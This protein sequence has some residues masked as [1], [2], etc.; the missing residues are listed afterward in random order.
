M[1]LV[2][3]QLHLFHQSNVERVMRRAGGALF[4]GT[5]VT[6]VI[7][8]PVIASEATEHG[9]ST[10]TIDGVSVT[11]TDS[12]KA[13]Y[14]DLMEDIAEDYSVSPRSHAFVVHTESLTWI[15]FTDQEPEVAEVQI[16]GE[17]IGTADGVGYIFANSV[18]FDAVPEPAS[19][20]TLATEP[21][22]H[23]YELVT[24]TTTYRQLSYAF[25]AAGG[26][27]RNQQ[28][29]GMAT[30]GSFNETTFPME[31]GRWANYGV[32][33]LSVAKNT[34]Q[35][36]FLAAVPLLSSGESIHAFGN[37]PSFG[38]NGTVRIKAVVL[39]RGPYQSATQESDQVALY[40]RKISPVAT[41]VSGPDEINNRGSE[42]EGEIVSFETNLVGSKISSKDAMIKL[43]SCGQDAVFV[44]GSCMPVVTDITIHSGIAFDNVPNSLNDSVIYAGLSNLNVD[45]VS[46]PQVGTFEVTGRVVDVDSIDPRFPEG[47]GLLVYSMK[48]T[49]G[50]SVSS[51]EEQQAREISDS[52][53]STMISQANAS[54]GEW[55]DINRNAPT[56]P[57]PTPSPT[58]T[59]TSTAETDSTPAES[60]GR[61]YYFTPSPTP[62]KGL[63]MSDLAT[64]IGGVFVFIGGFGMA[65]LVII[66]IM[67]HF[68]KKIRPDEVSVDDDLLEKIFLANSALIVLGTIP[69]SHIGSIFLFVVLGG[70]FGAVKTLELMWE[71]I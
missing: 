63:N 4:V 43:S 31:P 38:V 64:L 2:V 36:W 59:P 9:L 14:M 27:F 1:Q 61:T 56:T 32:G 3:W 28:I 5:V 45:G 33:T 65:T 62:G 69:F 66:T 49:G 19:F 22:R 21:D 48:R 51:S 58:P 40:V 68:K 44:G 6:A 25:D 12:R 34:T 24:V 30:N 60:D 55:E 20:K 71:V 13:E 54:S 50:P 52:V 11:L 39:N 57:T 8:A 29:I 15:V 70:S 26:D 10:R 67:V 37:G 47:Y 53:K 35:R 17:S 23:Q 7:A 42:L 16:T 46:Q 18:S 41:E